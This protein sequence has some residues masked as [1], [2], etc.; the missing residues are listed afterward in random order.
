MPYDYVRCVQEYV[1]QHLSENITVR[2]IAETVGLH[3]SYLNTFFH[4]QTGVSIKTFIHRVKTE[5][6]QRLLRESSYS[7][8]E[9]GTMLGYFD[10]SHFSRVFRK[11]AGTTPKRYRMR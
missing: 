11:F 7:I 6:A 2:A 1:R 4:A 10:Q 3:P 8:S 9:I 5:E